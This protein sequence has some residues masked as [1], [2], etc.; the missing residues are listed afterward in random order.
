MATNS[1]AASFNVFN[2]A[3]A[4]IK[5]S[6]S[7]LDF[8]YIYRLI[9]DE[10]EAL[11]DWSQIN[12]TRQSNG[13]SG[14]LGTFIPSLSASSV[15]SGG[16]GMNIKWTVSDSFPVDKFDLYFSW[17]YDN[18][19]TY[20]DF[21]YTDTVTSNNY[22]ITIPTVSSVKASFVK[23]AVQVPTN[24]KIINSKARLYQSSSGITTKP[25]LDS[26]TI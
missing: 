5:D 25:I 12:R 9:T 19:T 20:T 24:I 2:N 7:E 4:T 11:T 22:Y 14:L 3:T 8:F 13:V 1:V 6:S 23:V 10:G 17:S 18:G 21:Q 16:V 26:G 15:E